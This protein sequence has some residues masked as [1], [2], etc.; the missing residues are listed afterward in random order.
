MN[1][2]LLPLGMAVIRFFL[3]LSEI[4]GLLLE[5]DFDLTNGYLTAKT[6]VKVRQKIRLHKVA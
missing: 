2:F 1:E 3:G 6:L 5:A 4:F